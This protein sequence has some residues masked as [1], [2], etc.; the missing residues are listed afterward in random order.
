MPRL[1]VVASRGVRRSVRDSP[2]ERLSFTRSKSDDRLPLF[3][4]LFDPLVDDLIDDTKFLGPIG[5]QKHVTL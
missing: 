1:L 4:N 3:G 5:G 2:V